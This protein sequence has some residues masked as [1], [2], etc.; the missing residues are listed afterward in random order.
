MLRMR[1]LSENARGSDELEALSKSVRAVSAPLPLHP[2]MAAFPPI[3][4][5]LIMLDRNCNATDK[6]DK[7]SRLRAVPGASW[8]SWG[9]GAYTIVSMPRCL[10]L[11][12]CL[13]KIQLQL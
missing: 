11:A 9:A 10:L 1:P 12:H 13:V 7:I 6:I 5:Y 3:N 4:S 2:G 8:T